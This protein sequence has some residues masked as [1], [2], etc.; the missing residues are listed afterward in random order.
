MVT[1]SFL[2][3]VFSACNKVC[4]KSVGKKLESLMGLNFDSLR[5]INKCFE[6]ILIETKQPIN[7]F[8]GNEV[9]AIYLAISLKPLGRPYPLTCYPRVGMNSFSLRVAFSVGLIGFSSIAAKNSFGYFL[10]GS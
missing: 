7:S 8:I 2:N 9:S 6:G 4:L 3:T 1:V 5:C 10:L